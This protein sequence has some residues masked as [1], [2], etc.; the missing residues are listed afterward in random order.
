[1]KNFFYLLAF[2]LPVAF[3][4]CDDD[5]VE[6]DPNL[7]ISAGDFEVNQGSSLFVTAQAS[8]ADNIQSISADI[9]GIG[10]KTQTFDRDAVAYSE[11]FDI[12]ADQAPGDYAMT[13]TVTDGAGNTTTVTRNVKV[14]EFVPFSCG[15]DGNVT[16]SVIVPDYTPEDGKAI[17][18][19]GNFQGWDPAATPLNQDPDNPQ[20]WCISLDW[21]APPIEFK[22]AREDWPFVEKDANGDE[23]DNRIYVAD[24]GT[25]VEYTV[26]CWADICQ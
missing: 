22:F 12:A 11:S 2:V 23:I 6:L 15:D 19:A 17:T 4:S 16:V 21:S 10:N 9:A 5:T 1:M 3:V 26:E 14:N 7:L 25:E 18:I 13:L 20:R 24:D 8:D